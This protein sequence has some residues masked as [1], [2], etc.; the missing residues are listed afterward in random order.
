MRSKFSKKRLDILKNY[1]EDVIK[2]LLINIFAAIIFCVFFL[3]LVDN[4]FNLTLYPFLSI[5]LLWIISLGFLF[6]KSF[7]RN[8]LLWISSLF[9]I[10]YTITLNPEIMTFIEI[11]VT[12]S[13]FYEV[14]MRFWLGIEIRF[15]FEELPW[16]FQNTPTN[17]KVKK[18]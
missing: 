16:S 14:L 10:I 9:V 3:V 6:V 15:K 8:P 12:F 4:P 13:F 11:F 2:F 1:K 5:V 17:S 7:N 18:K